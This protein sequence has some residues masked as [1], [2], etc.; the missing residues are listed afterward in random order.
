MTARKALVLAALLGA[1][2]APA[3]AQA[4]EVFATTD[5]NLR[6][7][8]S[9]EFPVV[10]AIP[11]Q[12][13]VEFHGCLEGRSWC[14]VT[15]N[16]NR[17][18]AYGRYLA[19]QTASVRTVVTQ[20]P[21]TVEVPTVTYDTAEYW[22]TYYRDRPFY[23]QRERWI[24]VADGTSPAAGAAAGA[25]AGGAIG[26]PV[27]A[28]AGGVVG[29]AVG[30]AGAV[31]GGAVGTA[32]AVVDAVTNVP[33]RVRTYVETAPAEPV[34]VERRVVVGSTLPETVTLHPVPDYQY[35]YAYV[36]QSRVLVEPG[37][38]RVVQIID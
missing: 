26:G 2:W 4:Q 16:G 30:T 13:S 8:P 35:E 22:D 28:V 33:D 19:Y 7:G 25:A 6:A 21:A 37:T 5:L 15:F 36:N 18:W 29:G 11:A 23:Q 24:H 31:V 3:A 9:P 1:A 10:T 38:R 14:D 34:V 17:G 27:G 32:G 12:Q 20:A